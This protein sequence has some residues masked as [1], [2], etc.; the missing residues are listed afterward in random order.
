MSTVIWLLIA[1]GAVALVK[2]WPSAEVKTSTAAPVEPSATA[3]QVWS[4]AGAGF[5]NL[6]A[7]TPTVQSGAA[8]P[9]PAPGEIVVPPTLAPTLAESQGETLDKVPVNKPEPLKVWYTL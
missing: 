2:K 1:V 9:Q 4:L 7:Y 6:R 8:V 5:R 3:T